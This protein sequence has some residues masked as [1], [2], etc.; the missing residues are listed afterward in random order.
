M[1]GTAPLTYQ[2]TFIQT[3]HIFYLIQLFSLTFRTFSD[4]QKISVKF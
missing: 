1:Y 4:R 3:L 2:T